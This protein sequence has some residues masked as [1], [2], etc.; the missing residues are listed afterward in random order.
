MNDNVK[1]LPRIFYRVRPR[2][3]QRK[4]V[5][6]SNLETSLKA[7]A[8]RCDKSVNRT[9]PPRFEAKYGYILR[10]TGPLVE[11]GEEEDFRVRIDGN[12]GQY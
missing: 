11:G 10:L 5:I 7:Q 2:D 12:K 9:P 1:P 8:R 4:L 6:K 3:K